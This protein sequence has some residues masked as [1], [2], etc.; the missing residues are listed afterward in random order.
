MRI[1]WLSTFAV[2]GTIAVVLP[3]CRSARHR[4]AETPTGMRIACRLCYDEMKRVS[5]GAIGKQKR[6]WRT[7]HACEG[8]NA[9]SS[10]YW[11]DGVV[12]MKCPEC[13]PEGIPCDR[14]LPPESPRDAPY[15]LTTLVGC[16]GAPSDNYR[17]EKDVA[18]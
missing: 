2:F 16:R 10:I 5:R 3:G 13:A 6:G 18:Q 7:R 1:C 11:E 15:L 17:A 14:C 9:E 4:M 8:C 12:K